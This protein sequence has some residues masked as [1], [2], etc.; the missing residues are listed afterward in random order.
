MALRCSLRRVVFSRLVGSRFFASDITKSKT[1][2]ITVQYD[3]KKV[4][5]LT[6][7]ELIAM[8]PPIEIES[9]IVE[10]TGAS[11]DNPGHPAEYIQLNRRNKNT[12]ETCKYCGLRYVMK[13]GWAPAGH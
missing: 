8:V 10:C 9:N 3:L 2:T 7:M 5:E 13:K 4:H 11:N 1:T 12:P 6:P